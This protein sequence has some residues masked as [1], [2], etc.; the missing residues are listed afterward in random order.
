MN[1]LARYRPYALLCSILLVGCIIS[2]YPVAEVGINDEWSYVRS[3]DLM[4]STGHMVYMGWASAMLGWLI[5]LGALF[6]KIFGFSFTAVR[7]SGSAVA[8]LNAFVMQRCFV[9]SG[10]SERNGTVATLAIVLSPLYLP[11]A[12]TFMSDLPGMA[13][14]LLCYYG[15]LRAVQAS[16]DKA[17]TTWLVAACVLTAVGGTARQS[18]WLGL[19]IMVPCACWI[20]RGRRLPWIGIVVAWLGSVAFIFAA[21]HWFSRQPYSLNE[22]LVAAYVDRDLITPFLAHIARTVFSVCFFLV[23]LTVAFVPHLEVRETR[24]RRLIYFASAATAGFAIS[25]LARHHF[26]SWLAP[27]SGNCFTEKGLMDVQFGARPVVLEPWVRVLLT[28]FTLVCT[29]AAL[30]Y[31]GAASGR[32]TP[33]SREGQESPSWTVILVLLLPSTAAY[34]AML[35]HRA[36]FAYVFDRYLLTVL[37]VGALLL[38]RFYQ[39]R[40]SFRLPAACIA[41]VAV[42][43]IFAVAANHDLFAMERARVAAT[44]ELVRSGIGRERFYGGWEYDGWTQVDHYG[45]VNTGGLRMPSGVSVNPPIRYK[46]E[47]KPCNNRFA[48]FY[49][50]IHPEYEVS[51]EPTDC[52]GPSGFPPIEYRLWLPP[53]KA[54]IYITRVIVASR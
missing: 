30:S 51:F 23:P 20:L 37:F 4:A 24:A 47:P 1:D 21:L 11:L 32:R 5:P 31:C 40:I 2:S 7:A 33:A 16:S 22:E 17:A 45:F 19:L 9:R 14:W 35:A 29:V 49:P 8:V 39:E 43:A 15:C 13:V 41:A 26:V 27:F 52:N 42:S 6:V 48:P 34:L 53:Y 44:Q 12:T 25:L 10:L 50:A 28:L 54:D 3:A 18:A 38:V 36:L 46:V